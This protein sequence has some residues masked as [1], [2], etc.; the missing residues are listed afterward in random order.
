M[1]EEPIVCQTS[2]VDMRWLHKREDITLI[3]NG[4]FDIAQGDFPSIFSLI[5]KFYELVD[6]TVDYRLRTI[7][8]SW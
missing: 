2:T 5:S 8:D 6:H 7:G 3:L 4:C 1:T